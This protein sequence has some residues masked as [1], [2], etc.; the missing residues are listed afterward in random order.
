MWLMVRQN[1]Q[2]LNS[3]INLI[4]IYRQLSY[5]VPIVLPEAY[6]CAKY[7]YLLLACVYR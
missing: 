3:D 1:L 5:C 2:L 6:A 4:T 7:V